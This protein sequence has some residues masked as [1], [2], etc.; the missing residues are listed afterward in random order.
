MVAKLASKEVKV[1][2]GGDGSDELSFGY[3]FNEG[4]R[5]LENLNN[6]VN[7]DA[8][9]LIL[10]MPFLRSSTIFSKAR[11]ASEVLNSLE[12]GKDCVSLGLSPFKYEG[13]HK[14][15]KYELLSKEQIF[16]YK[17][18][19]NCLPPDVQNRV[20]NN[21]LNGYLKNN[22]LVK[23]DR[24]T[25]LNSIELRSPFLDKKLSDFL[26]MHNYETHRL[27]GSNKSLLRSY[28]KEKLPKEVL[29]KRKS[30]FGFP[31]ADWLRSD[32]GIFVGEV[33]SRNEL[34][35][36]Y[37]DKK[38]VLNLLTEHRKGTTDNS[39][40]LWSLLILLSWRQNMIKG[41]TR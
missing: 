28:L 10:K 41:E 36:E 23:T 27:H 38:E 34:Y 18:G 25:M 4:L 15:L 26:L 40:I 13:H 3:N 7:R 6:L 11:F 14:I 35:P 19:D 17:E 20:R 33:L 5:K 1:A 16:G 24:M 29:N 21:Y 9:R 31:V 32:F 30:G 39:D 37:L 2:L 8:I 22:I 12:D